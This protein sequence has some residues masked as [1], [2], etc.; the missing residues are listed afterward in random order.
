MTATEP[1]I[2]ATR[3]N[4]H[5]IP[6]EAVKVAGYVTGL[7]AVPWT[8]AEWALFPESGHVRIDQS[9]SLSSF[10]QGLADVA[11]LEYLAGTVASFV[12]AVESRIDLGI[13]WSTAYGT[14]ST[15]AAV[16]GALEAAGPHGWYFGHVD[17][18]LADWNLSEAQA[19]GVVGTLVHGLTC[20]AVQWAS[21]SSNP[22]T[23][24]PGSGLTLAQA[25]V[26]LSVAEDSW[27]PA[28]V[29]QPSAAR[30]YVVVELPDGT[31]FKALSGT[32]L[33]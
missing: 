18:W 15:L 9:P 7:G 13:T 22:G 8:A 10:A 17:A 29:T 16:E 27:H 32:V 3:V 31:A 19:A 4:A 28:P 2:D 21:P 24:V 30:T 20:R 11:D 33:K 26:D 23:L 14:D 25:Q 1:M 12:A 6:R 5:N